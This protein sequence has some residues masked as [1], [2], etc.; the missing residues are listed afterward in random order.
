MVLSNENHRSARVKKHL[1]DMV[2]FDKEKIENMILR[3]VFR[4]E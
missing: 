4:D 2:K 3:L 1:D